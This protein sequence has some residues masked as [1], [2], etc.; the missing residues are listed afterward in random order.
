MTLRIRWLYILTAIICIIPCVYFSVRLLHRDFQVF[1]EKAVAFN[2]R[3]ISRTLGIS[4]FDNNNKILP[5]V[6]ILLLLAVILGSGFILSIILFIA[7]YI[8]ILAVLIMFGVF[9]L[10]FGLLFI[11]EQIFILSAL[12]GILI[13]IGINRL[14]VYTL[15]YHILVS[16]GSLWVKKVAFTINIGG[17]DAQKERQR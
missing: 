2:S 14:T 10:V 8:F 12:L 15:A 4:R 5:A 1:L 7:Y 11:L 6:S 3:Q 13:G 9:Y 16:I 17:K